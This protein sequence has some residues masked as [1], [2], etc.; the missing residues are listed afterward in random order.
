M[1]TDVTIPCSIDFLLVYTHPLPYLSI[2]AYSCLQVS[3]KWHEIISKE[4]RYI[5]KIQSH[6]KSLRENSK[7]P[8]LPLNLFG[9]RRALGTLSQNSLHS[10]SNNL[11]LLSSSTPSYR[12]ERTIKHL[13]CPT[14][15]S[16]ARQ[17]NLRRTVCTNPVC[18]LDFCRNC[19]RHWH[20]GDCVES[21]ASRSPKRGQSTLIVCSK[22]AKKRLRRL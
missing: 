5:E 20:E 13:P 22:K 19:F 17:L 15:R 21:I 8:S 11:P 12:A 1:Y 18:Q 6:L 9:E 4:P 10:R 2:L 7:K 14:C 3:R 16:P